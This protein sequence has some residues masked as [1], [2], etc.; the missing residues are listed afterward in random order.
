MTK[1][2]FTIRTNSDSN[3]P[4]CPNCEYFDETK[5]REVP[6][7]TGYCKAL[8]VVL[9]RFYY[10]CIDFNGVIPEIEVVQGD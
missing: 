4:L 2:H 6:S 5:Y 9:Y 3:P 7:S 8:N 1:E 10:V